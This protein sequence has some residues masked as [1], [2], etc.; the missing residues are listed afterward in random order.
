[1]TK[2]VIL[3]ANNN[4]EIDYVRQ[5]IFCAKHI[6][7]HLN[8]P[9]SLITDSEK[10]L[11]TKYPH[12]IDIFDKV[13]SAEKIQVYQRKTFRDG[14]QVSKKLQWNN[15]NRSDAYNLTPYD[16]TIVMDTDYIV[17]NDL[18]LNCFKLNDD[19]MIWKDSLYINPYGKPWEIRYVSD[20]SIEMYWATVF[21]FK[22]NKKMETFFEL[23]KYIK[24]NWNYYRW[25]YQIS[26][27]NFRNDFAFSIAIHIMNGF[28]SSTHWPTNPPGSLYYI[29]DRDLVEDF[30]DDEFTFLC[31]LPNDNSNYS[32]ATTK[33][34]NVHVMNKIGLE[35]LIERQGI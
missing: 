14:R 16:E 26:G 27:R 3:F 4:D 17:G 8:L 25:I 9:V 29:F 35:Q 20:T 11:Q 22:K 24:E 10:H 34:L 1:M 32:V 7:K 28:E 15:F 30:K 19:F 33:D 21:Y 23:L 31:T 2:G 6:K 18:L 12:L 5:A 13:I